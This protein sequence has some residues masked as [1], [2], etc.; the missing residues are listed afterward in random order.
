MR[1]EEFF[2]RL[3]TLGDEGVR[4]ALWNLYW[5]GSAA[6][7]ERIELQVGGDA[8]ATGRRGSADV[9]DVESVVG[10][11]G[12]FAM[13]ARRGAYLASNRRVSP[14]ERTR[15]RFTFQRLSANAE[16][17][18]HNAEVATAATAIEELVDLA[19]E[20]R[21]Y[22]YFRSE[23]PVE[24]AEFVVSDAVAR[25]WTTVRDRYGFAVFAERAAPQLIRWESP[26]G[27]T[28]RGVGSG[29]RERDVARRGGGWDAAGA[30]HV[31]RLR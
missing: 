26:Y 24:A 15:W 20:T 31:G 30:R 27:W 22:D 2:D 19:C 16:S 11:V 13:L 12:E 14:R 21:E 28:R 7:R 1:R 18:L 10:E 8:A 9:A 3:A 6:M 29:Q 25:L 23:D 4:R 17:A 5:Q